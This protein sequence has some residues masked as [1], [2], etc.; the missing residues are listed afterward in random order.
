MAIAIRGSLKLNLNHQIK[1]WIHHSTTRYLGQNH[2]FLPQN[3]FSCNCSLSSPQ[4]LTNQTPLLHQQEEE[5]EKEREQ[6][7][8]IMCE[9]C[10]GKGW[11]LCD[12]CNGQK[13]NV[14]TKKNRIYRRCPT[15][16]AV[17]CILCEKCKVYKCV[18]FPDFFDD[19]N[20]L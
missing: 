2:L 15:C 11:L 14:Q 1:P 9:A 5:N 20:Q 16:K 4:Q 6:E 10:Q 3:S 12:F 17:G 18:T 8:G 13:V 7:D 19:A